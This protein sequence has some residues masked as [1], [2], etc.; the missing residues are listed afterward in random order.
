MDKMKIYD[1]MAALIEIMLAK[2]NK[3]KNILTSER[4]NALYDFLDEIDDMR[5]QIKLEQLEEEGED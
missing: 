4:V 1:G 3:E 5:A 2:A